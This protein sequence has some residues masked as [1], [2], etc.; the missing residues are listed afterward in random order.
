M[1]TSAV[2]QLSLE[3]TARHEI[4]AWMA[5]LDLTQEQLADRLPNVA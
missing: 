4:K 3:Q 5:R 1:S 2:P